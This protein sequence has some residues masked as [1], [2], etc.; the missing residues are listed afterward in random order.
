MQ[1]PQPNGQQEQQQE[2]QQDEQD[3]QQDGKGGK[4]VIDLTKSSNRV[5][6]APCTWD[7]VGATCS[8]QVHRSM[9]RPC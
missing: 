9:P 2:G 3:K 5:R 4:K 6:D 1:E 8:A 7:V